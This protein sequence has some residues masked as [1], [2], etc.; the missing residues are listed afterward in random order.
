MKP[1]NDH[2]P[3]FYFAVTFFVC[4]GIAFAMYLMSVGL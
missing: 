3:F 2:N 4:G 1:H